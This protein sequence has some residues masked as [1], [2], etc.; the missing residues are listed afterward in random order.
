[1]E[2]ITK[3]DLERQVEV[4]NGYFG[5]RDNNAVGRFQIEYAYGDCRLV[6]IIN[7]GDGERNMSKRGTKRE[8]YEKLYA[9]NN[10]IYQFKDDLKA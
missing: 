1:M 4:L 3:Q 7:A 8:I 2:R 9:I 5:I 10:V 6:R